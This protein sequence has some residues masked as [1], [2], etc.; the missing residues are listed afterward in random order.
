MDFPA[1][2]SAVHQYRPSCA[3]LMFLSGSRDPRWTLLSWSPDFNHVTL[4]GGLPVALQESIISLLSFSVV[5]PEIAKMLG[6]TS[7]IT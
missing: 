3:L 4:G 7:E 6:R 2:L 5:L 1:L